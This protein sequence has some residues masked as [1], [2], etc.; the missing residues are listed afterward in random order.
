MQDLLQRN[1]FQV[2]E[3]II[4]LDLWLKE[5]PPALPHADELVLRPMQQSDLPTVAAVDAAAF[6]PLWQNPIGDLEKAYARSAWAILAE[7]EEQPV[8]YLLAIQSFQGVHIARLAVH[9]AAQRRG[10]GR[11]LCLDLLGASWQRGWQHIT[12]NTQES[13]QNALN[14]Y[15]SL[16]FLPDK[17]RYPVFVRQFA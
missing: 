4:N 9:P 12:V 6:V 7:I 14:L 1:G 13:N 15:R 3:Y 17:E 11:A 16:G 10:V 8:G 2:G 5:P